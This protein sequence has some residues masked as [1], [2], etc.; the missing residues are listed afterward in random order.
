MAIDVP[1]PCNFLD[2]SP[3]ARFPESRSRNLGTRNDRATYGGNPHASLIYHSAA[4][5]RLSRDRRDSGKHC[6]F[7]VCPVGG[8]LLYSRPVLGGRFL[9][10][11]T[12]QKSF[13]V[14][15]PV[16]AELRRIIIQHESSFVTKTCLSGKESGVG[17]LVATRRVAK[18]ERVIAA[19][20]ATVN[21][22]RLSGN[23][24]AAIAVSIAAGRAVALIDTWQPSRVSVD[25]FRRQVDNSGTNPMRTRG[26]SARTVTGTRKATPNIT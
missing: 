20:S 26:S 21:F 22:G 11:S 10:Q 6:Q 24:A 5:P 3:L 25:G 19:S 4:S 1:I 17:C 9:G 23:G 18:S 7:W 2:V 16:V 14:R 12:G 15:K 13:A 8:S